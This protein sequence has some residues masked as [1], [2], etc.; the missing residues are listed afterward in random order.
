MNEELIRTTVLRMIQEANLGGDRPVGLF[1]KYD[2]IVDEVGSNLLVDGA[3]SQLEENRF[4]REVSS[5]FEQAKGRPLGYKAYQ[6]TELGKS[7][8]GDKGPTNVFH[9]ITNSNIAVQSPNTTQTINIEDL[10]HDLQ[11][12]VR[13][14]D[15][16]AQQK[17]KVA[18]KKTF[19]YIADKSVDAAIALATGVLLR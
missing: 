12:K 2:D 10:S 7:S 4:I 8:L 14:F 18:L 1:R 5:A 3:I 6:I 15:A 19:G 9:G 17:D 11:Q 16:A 13:E